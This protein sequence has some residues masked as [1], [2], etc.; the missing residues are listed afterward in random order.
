M[1]QLPLTITKLI[2]AEFKQ[3]LIV[4]FEMKL[5]ILLQNHSILL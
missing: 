2:Q 5:S 1:L 4:R 3:S